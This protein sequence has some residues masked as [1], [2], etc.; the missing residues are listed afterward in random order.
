MTKLAIRLFG[1]DNAKTISTRTF[2][3]RHWY[4]ACDICRLVA[5]SNYSAAVKKRFKM[6]AYTLK[7]L[8]HQLKALYTGTSRRRVLLVND[9]GMLKLIMQSNSAYNAEIQA[10]ALEA[11]KTL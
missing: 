1:S 6:D 5:I 9:T 2:D 8:E 4:M 3:G 10:R 11:M 7:P